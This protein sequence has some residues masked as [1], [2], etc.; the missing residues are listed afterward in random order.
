MLFLPAFNAVGELPR[1]RAGRVILTLCESARHRG[2]RGLFSPR[3]L[4]I[5]LMEKVIV[6]GVGNEMR[7][8]DAF[9]LRLVRRMKGASEAYGAEY[10][11]GGT[12]GLDLL[13]YFEKAACLILVDAMDLGLEG[14][15][16]L[17]L[18]EEEIAS[19]FGDHP[20]SPHDVKLPELVRIAARMGVKPL[21]I[22]LVA[23]QVVQTTR[24]AGLSPQVEA[25]LPAAEELVRGEIER[26]RS[27]K[28]NA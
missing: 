4:I 27:G 18:G 12:V 25:A 1:Y 7:G 14:G 24:G 23:V 17:L 10:I 21:H 19:T 13:R 11:E 3:W 28:G 15:T 2:S 26:Y 9:G 20:L 5:W 16:V 8:D 22:A 6:I